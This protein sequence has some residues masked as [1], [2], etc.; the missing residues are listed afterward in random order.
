VPTAIFA[1]PDS[2][3]MH[4]RRL[5]GIALVGVV[6]LATGFVLASQVKAQLLTPSNQVARYQALVLSV[7]ELEATNA[8]SRRDIAALRADIDALEVDAATR[9]AATQSLRTQV[10]DLRAH[11]GLVAVHG[12]G[13]E[14]DLRSG[15]A[16][17]SVTGTGYLVTYED[18]QDVVNLLFAQGAEGAAV[19]GRR[20]TPL[21]AFSGSAGQVIID[22]ES[23]FTSP[24]KIV[25]VGDRNRMVAAL[26]DS[27]SLPSIRAREI[28]FDVHLTFFGSPDVSLPASDS[29]LQVSHVA[30]A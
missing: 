28:E 19:N 8:D 15:D 14:V 7:Q 11:A 13:V 21:S 5:L 10:G 23:P 12:P 1:I 17:T 22:Q 16:N 25:A 26:D 27:S 4:P 6:A 3:A 2:N 18:V 29:S 9:S 30:P 20:I 24:I